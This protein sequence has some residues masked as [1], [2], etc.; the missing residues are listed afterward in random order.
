MICGASLLNTYANLVFS[1]HKNLSIVPRATSLSTKLDSIFT[2]NKKGVTAVIHTA[3]P[4]STSNTKWDDAITPAVQGSLGILNSA[5]K[6]SGPKL[7]SSVLTSSVSAV[8]DPSKKTHR[9]TEADWNEWAEPKAKNGDTS[10]LYSASKTLAERAIWEFRDEKKV[11][12]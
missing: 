11:R 2:D 3:S 5:Y 7:E 6:H 12:F 10:A 1:S 8:S 4:I 9:F